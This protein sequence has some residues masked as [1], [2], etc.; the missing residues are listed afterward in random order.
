M[1]EIL[2]QILS[3]SIREDIALSRQ[4]AEVYKYTT[5]NIVR[6]HAKEFAQMAHLLVTT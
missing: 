4:V 5:F 3:V 1:L 2:P 6:L